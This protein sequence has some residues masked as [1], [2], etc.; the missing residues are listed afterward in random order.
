MEKQADFERKEIV[1]DFNEPSFN[2]TRI[3]NM[4]YHIA[5]ELH[6]IKRILEER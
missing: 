1:K 6:D 3:R 5:I 2:E 4:L